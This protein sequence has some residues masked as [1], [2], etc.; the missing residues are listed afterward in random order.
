M[1][2]E[3]GDGRWNMAV[4]ETLLDAVGRGESG[5]VIRLY[6]FDPPTLSVGRFQPTDGVVDFQLIE[7]EGIGFVRRPSGGQAVL[8]TDEL[9]Y[10][11][12]IGKGDIEPFGKRWVYRFVAPLLMAGLGRLGVPGVSSSPLQKGDP[13]N[14]DCFG[15]T[16]EYEI[17]SGGGRKLI[18]SAQM[19]TRTAVLQHGSIPLSPKGREITRYLEV[20]RSAEDHASNIRDELAQYLEFTEVRSAFVEALGETLPIE[21]SSLRPDEEK[22]A[23]QLLSEKYS[24]DAWNRKY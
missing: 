2:H 13:T 21:S 3:P 24:T 15:S 23:S 8:H 9:T 7:S 4:D 18:G 11:F 5:P 12:I 14:P 20:Q 6:G 17:D 22:R 10:A 16:G 19:I 1:V